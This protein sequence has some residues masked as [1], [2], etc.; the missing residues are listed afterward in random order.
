MKNKALKLVCL[1]LCLVLALSAFAG[2]KGKTS[3]AKKKKK[4]TKKAESTVSEEF[5][6]D[7]ASEEWIDEEGDDDFFEED[8]PGDDDGDDDEEEEEPDSVAVATVSNGAPLTQNVM[9]AGM[10]LYCPYAFMDSEIVP[11]DRVANAEFDRLQNMG[12]HTVRGM[13]KFAWLDEGRNDGVWNWDSSLMQAYYKWLQGMKDRNIN[14]FVNPWSFAHIANIQSYHYWDTLCFYEDTFEK[15]IENWATAMTDVMLKLR[16]KGYTNANGL[17]LFTEP[18]YAA[19]VEARPELN[20]QYVYMA[21]LIDKKLKTAGIRQSI[22]LMGPN[23][24]ATDT[25][26]IEKCMTEAYDVFDVFSQHRYVDLQDITGNTT[27]DIAV[28]TYSPFVEKVKELNKA[29]KPF[30][31]DEYNVSVQDALSISNIGFDNIYRGI[32]QA[33]TYNTCMNMGG[34]NGMMIWTIADQQWPDNRG[35][36]PTAGFNDG[37]L[38]HGLLPDMNKTMVPK[39]QYYAF[40]LLSKYT[41]TKGNTVY[42]VECDSL[43]VTVSAIKLPDGNWTF[44]VTNTNIENT[45]FKLDFEKELNGLKLYRHQYVASEVKPTNAAHIIP[46]S[47]TIKNVKTG[48]TDVLKPYSVAVYTTVKG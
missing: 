36:T 32:Q 24:A 18:N 33:V 8:D 7:T 40:S 38:E 13:F 25:V 39:S 31:I 9:G 16:A 45:L 20:D 30:W 42:R 1:L 4:S 29:N 44:I 14:V 43:E 19:D 41:G 22:Q 27:Q 11:R 28:G 35:T 5:T 23:Y 6:S 3:A 47:K 34:V 48:F 10:G 26:L 15:T 12:I 46:A 21:K 2:C 37:V 17:L